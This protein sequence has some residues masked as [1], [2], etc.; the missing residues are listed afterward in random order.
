MDVITIEQIVFKYPNINLEEFSKWKNRT[1]LAEN[2][3]LLRKQL[4]E[5]RNK[6]K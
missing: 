3:L 5:A 2:K 6:N 4:N 1:L